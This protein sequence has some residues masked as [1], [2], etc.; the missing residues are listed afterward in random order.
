MHF[1]IEIENIN[2]Q[3]LM[4]Q[5]VLNLNQNLAHEFDI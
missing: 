2:L 3:I 5:H 1:Q 4:M